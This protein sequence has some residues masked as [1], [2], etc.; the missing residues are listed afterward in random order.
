MSLS[1]PGMRQLLPVSMLLGAV[2]LALV[3]DLAYILGMSDSL[4]LFTSCIGAVVMT[5]TLLRW[6]EA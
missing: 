4:N 1:G 6:K 3:W 2:L 5:V